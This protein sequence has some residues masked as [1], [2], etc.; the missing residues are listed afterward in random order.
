MRTAI[1]LAIVASATMIG[2]LQQASPANAAFHLMRIHA[3]MHGFQGNNNIQYVELRMCSAGQSFVSGHTIDFY[4][5]SNV[6]KARFTFPGNVSFGSTGESILIA[7]SEFDAASTGP[8]AGGSGGDADFVFSEANTAAFNGGDALHPVQGPDGKVVFAP[9][10]TDGCDAGFGVQAGDVDSVA[11]GTGT[12][13]FGS[14]APALPSPSDNRALRESDI[15]GPSDNSTDYSLQAT[16]AAPKTV[17]MASLTT[18]LDTPRNN[19]RQVA[20]LTTIADED[21][22]GVPDG[23]DLCPGTGA[24]EPV[25]A[26]GCSDLQVDGDLDSV[27]DPGA[28]SVGPSVCAGSDNCPNDAN[29]GQ[30]NFDADS[31]GDVCDPD[32][33]DDTILDGSDPDDDNDGIPDAAEAACGGVTPSLLRPERVD[34]PF[35]GVTDDADGDVDEALPG[36]SSGFDCDGDGYTGAAEDHV[37]SYDGQTNGDQ[38][39]CQ[40]YD[41]DFSSLDPNQTAA[42]PSL[43]WPSDFRTG[44][45]PNSTNKINILD[46]ASFVAP[47]RYFGTNVGAHP[48]DVRWDISPGKGPLA[49]DINVLDLAAL[50]APGAVTG[51]PPM[52]GGVRA[53]LGPECPWAE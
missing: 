2:V 48:A 49:V 30:E 50:T 14:A 33:D 22:D 27:C 11:Y 20:T 42:T 18:D 53:F 3:V 35:A 45:V 34:G 4:D 6:L 21:G 19:S 16:A 10:A 15:T 5:G 9:L 51:A 52:L 7:T 26:N 28:P 36:G 23:S 8:G 40:E 37:F 13:D 43:R 41:S 12:P 25:D 39:T 29:P 46:L 31:L 24:A 38:K 1:M 17:A 47:V 32:D 44:S